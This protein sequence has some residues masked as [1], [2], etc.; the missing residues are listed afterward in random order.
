METSAGARGQGPEGWG[1]GWG[2]NIGNCKFLTYLKLCS[3][4][5]YLT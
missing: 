4:L 3:K 1:G 5:E 2:G